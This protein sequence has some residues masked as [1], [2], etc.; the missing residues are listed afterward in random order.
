ML[1]PD[2][3]RWLAVGDVYGGGTEYWVYTLDPDPPPPRRRIG[4]GHRN[5][6]SGQSTAGGHRIRILLP[7]TSRPAGHRIQAPPPRRRTVGMQ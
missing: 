3:P 4:G 6:P 2:N 1:R 7:C 5:H